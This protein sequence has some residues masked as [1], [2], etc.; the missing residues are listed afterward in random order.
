M[1][2]YEQNNKVAETQLRG[3]LWLNFFYKYFDV[4]ESSEFVVQP[5]WLLNFSV[6]D[7]ANLELPDGFRADLG[8]LTHLK[9]VFNKGAGYKTGQASTSGIRRHYLIVP[10]KDDYYTEKWKYITLDLADEFGM[11]SKTFN[12]MVMI[13][14]YL[15]TKY[16]SGVIKKLTTWYVDNGKGP[17]LITSFLK[18][19]YDVK[20]SMNDLNEDY[21]NWVKEKGL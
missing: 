3:F 14:N 7:A 18:D 4:N 17:L 1:K 6:I 9:D 12:Q 16:G 21:L 19:H 2:D 15:K 13:V 11:E 5:K 10:R 20:T 8:K